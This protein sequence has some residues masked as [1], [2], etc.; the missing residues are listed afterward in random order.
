I[1]WC[2]RNLTDGFIPKR[3]VSQLLDLT[4]LQASEVTRDRGR[5]GVTPEDVAEDLAR[6]G[7]WHNHGSTWEPRDFPACNSS[8]TE[9]VRE[10]EQRRLRVERHRKRRRNGVTNATV[11]G[12]P[13]PVPVLGSSGEIL[14]LCIARGDPKGDS[15]AARAPRATIWPT[16]FTLT[17]ERA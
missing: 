6:I 17:R 16:D 12:V 10:R 3:R 9:V 11:T 4:S 2:A 13:V 1:T 8:R 15:R 14:E 5:Y 7:V